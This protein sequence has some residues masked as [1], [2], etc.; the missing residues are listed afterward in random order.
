MIQEA[1]E[2]FAP[3]DDAPIPWVWIREYG[4]HVF[5]K[6]RLPEDLRVKWRNLMKKDAGNLA[7][8]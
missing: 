8:M 3:Q 7:D 6:T 2:K 5:H 4:H 1:M